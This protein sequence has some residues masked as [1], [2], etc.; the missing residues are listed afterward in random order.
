MIILLSDC[1]NAINSTRL[2]VLNLLPYLSEKKSEFIKS[3]NGDNY[4]TNL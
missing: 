1:D 2:R 4:C 3:N